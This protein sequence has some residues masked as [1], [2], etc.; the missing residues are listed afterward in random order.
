MR[1][2]ILIS[3]LFYS[4]ISIGQQTFSSA[5]GNFVG[6]KSYLSFTVGEVFYENKGNS[7]DGIQQG[8]TVNR[9]TSFSSLHLTIFPNPT[10][11][12]LYFKVEDL[13]YT[14]LHYLI[15]D[16]SGLLLASGDISDT[17]SRISLKDLPSQNLIIKCFR[18]AYEQVTYK[19]IKLN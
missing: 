16:F 15:Y 17:K 3:V 4:F 10:T 11:D 12:L 1:A 7:K 8:F 14:N 19:V 6:S 9:I 5:G 18:S 13:N 2:F